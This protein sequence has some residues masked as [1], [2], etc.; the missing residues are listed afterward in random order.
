MFLIVGLGNVGKEYEKTRHNIGFD[1]IESFSERY[2]IPI[3]GEKFKGTYG[4]G[5]INGEKIIC[6]K[7]S[8]YM[9][10][11][12]DSVKLAMDYYHIDFNNL[13]ILY[14][15]ITLEPGKVRIRAK[16]SAGG[17]NGIKDII[18]KLGSDSFFRIKIGVGAPKDNLV[19]HVIGRFSKEDRNCVEKILNICPDIIQCILEK[20]ITEAM[21]Q[22]NGVD[23]RKAEI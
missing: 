12:G 20:G 5:R 14:D 16:G 22:Y 4:E 17:H 8:T 11:S 6:L 15:D 1:A 10:L 2:N 18:K 9:N 3:N 7:P 19:N 21:N 13:I 23:Y